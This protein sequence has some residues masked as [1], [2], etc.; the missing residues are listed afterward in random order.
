MRLN[1]GSFRSS[2]SAARRSRSIAQR[3]RCSVM[4]A[5]ASRDHALGM[6][7]AWWNRPAPGTLFL[8]EVS[9]LPLL[10]QGKT[11]A[12]AGRFEGIA[13]WAA[14]EMR[15]RAPVSFRRVNAD[16]SAFVGEGRFLV[17]LWSSAEPDRTAHPA[18]A[19]TAPGYYPSGD[20]TS[21]HSLAAA[22]ARRVPT[23]TPA[24]GVALRDHTWPGNIR[25]LRNRLERALP[26]SP[27]G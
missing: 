27:V 5:G 15:S 20:S 18:A 4:S 22:P 23:L 24:A 6:F 19:R 11:A 25:E 8:D 2:L 10:L 12:A 13:G 14:Q 17:D 3:A 16:P 1:G 9:A 26:L 21:S 7:P